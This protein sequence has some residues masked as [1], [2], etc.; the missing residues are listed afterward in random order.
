MKQAENAEPVFP[1]SMLGIPAHRLPLPAVLQ[2]PDRGLVVI[3]CGDPAWLQI[4][5]FSFLCF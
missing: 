4:I 5:L 3:S 2:F 1:P